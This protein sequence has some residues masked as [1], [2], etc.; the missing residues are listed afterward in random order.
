MA[1]RRQGKG[2]GG[3][4]QPKTPP[5][6]QDKT[7]VRDPF[8]LKGRQVDRATVRTAGAWRDAL[9]NNAWRI[10]FLLAFVLA[11]L[12][13]GLPNLDLLSS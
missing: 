13:W 12:F 9:H 10:A 8:S 11:A 2:G 4:G 7:E 5:A 3:G 1:D 6:T